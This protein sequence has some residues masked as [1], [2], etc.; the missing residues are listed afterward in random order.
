MFN[1]AIIKNFEIPSKNKLKTKNYLVNFG[2]IVVA[3]LIIL[4]SL[5]YF[6][7]AVFDDKISYPENLTDET[8]LHKY[9]IELDEEPLIALYHNKSQIPQRAKEFHLK[10]FDP[11]SHAVTF[12]LIQDKA[13]KIKQKQDEILS[14]ILS[15]REK[16][17]KNLKVSLLN[18]K[19][20][21]KRFSKV[22]SGLALELTPE[23]VEEIKSL[24]YVKSVEPDITLKFY[25]PTIPHTNP[26]SFS[27]E[28][29]TSFSNLNLLSETLNYTGKGIKVAII[30]SGVDYTH[31]DLGGCTLEQI[32]A[33]N[34][35]KIIDVYDFGEDDFDPMDDFG[36]GTHCAGII[37]ANGTLKGVAPDAQLMVYKVSYIVSINGGLIRLFFLPVSAIINAL[38][39]SLDPNDDLDFSDRADVISLSLGAAGGEANDYL[40]RIL[41]N[42]VKA[43]IFVSA[44]A[45]NDGNQ[46]YIVSDPSTSREAVSVAAYNS[47][48]GKIASFSSG[49]PALVWQYGS[50]ITPVGS[51]IFKPEIAAPGVDI[52]STAARG[53]C[54]LC[55]PSG[56]T[57]LSGTSMAT[58]Y[59][60]GVAALILERS[61]RENLSLT[62]RDVKS[63]ILSYAKDLG[64]PLWLQ[65]TGLVNISSS[66]N[67]KI[68]FDPPVINFEDL[69]IA[70][71]SKKNLRIRNLDNKTHTLHF[72]LSSLGDYSDYFIISNQTITINPQETVNV[73]LSLNS[74]KTMS[75][76]DLLGLIKVEDSTLD[77]SKTL[78]LPLSAYLFAYYQMNNMLG[79]KIVS[80]NLTCDQ[81]KQN[82]DFKLAILAK[83]QN[84]MPNYQLLN[85]SSS[86]L[87]E[88]CSLNTSFLDS[89]KVDFSAVLF[90]YVKYNN[91]LDYY[92]IPQDLIYPTDKSYV[93]LTFNLSDVKRNKVPMSFDNSSVFLRRALLNLVSK[94]STSPYDMH[95]NYFDVNYEAQYI[96]DYP[97]PI[98]DETVYFNQRDYDIGDHNY[99]LSLE[100]W[101]EWIKPK[102]NL[103]ISEAITQSR[104][105]IN[106]DVYIYKKRFVNTV[107]Q[108]IF[109]I[110]TSNREEYY[111]TQKIPFDLAKDYRAYRNIVYVNEYG[112]LRPEPIKDFL[113][114]GSYRIVEFEPTSKASFA[115]VNEYNVRNGTVL[116]EIYAKEYGTFYKGFSDYSIITSDQR[117]SFKNNV[118]LGSLI[119]SILPMS[120]FLDSLED[121]SGSFLVS[122]DGS[123]L[124]LYDFDIYVKNS[125]YDT[126]FYYGAVNEFLYSNAKYYY[127]ED[128]FLIP[129]SNYK[130]VDNQNL[131]ELTYSLYNLSIFNSVNVSLIFNPSICPEFPDVENLTFSREDDILNISFDYYILNS[132]TVALSQLMNNGTEIIKNPL[133]LTCFA[134]D[135]DLY[136]CYSEINLSEQ[137]LA[138][139]N[140][141]LFIKNN[142]CYNSQE[143]NISPFYIE[144][145][146]RY[147]NLSNK[148]VHT[149]E[150]NNISFNVSTEDG[151]LLKNFPVK[152]F[153]NDSFISEVIASENTTF[154]LNLSEY[155]S[156]PFIDLTF[157]S[158][159]NYPYL[160]LN[161]TVRYYLDFIFFSPN[162]NLIAD[163][164][165]TI[166]LSSKRADVCEYNLTYL[167]NSSLSSSGQLIKNG[168]FFYKTINLDSEGDYYLNVTCR[169]SS[170]ITVGFVERTFTVDYLPPSYQMILHNNLTAGN[171]TPIS[172]F[173]NEPNLKSMLFFIEDPLGNV[174]FSLNGISKVC[175]FS[176]IPWEIGNYSFT[177]NI[178]DIANHVTYA[179]EVYSSKEPENVS[180]IL[181]V[182]T[183]NLTI[184][185][186]E[187]NESINTSLNSSFNTTVP[188][189]ENVTLIIKENDTPHAKLIIENVSLAN[190][191]LSLDFVKNASENSVI[192]KIVGVKTIIPKLKSK[193][194]FNLS[195]INAN[196]DKIVPFK[197]Y[198][199]DMINHSCQGAWEEYNNYTKDLTKKII[200][201]NVSSFSAYSV[202]EEYY[203]GDSTCDPDETCDSCPQDCGSC[204]VVQPPSV[205]GGGGG[206]SIPSKQEVSF[207]CDYQQ[208]LRYTDLLYHSLDE[209]FTNLSNLSSFYINSHN[210]QE[211]FNRL[212]LCFNEIAE[213]GALN[214]EMLNLINLTNLSSQENATFLMY[215]LSAYL[216]DSRGNY[217]QTD[218]LNLTLNFRFNCPSNYC[219]FEFD[220]FEQDNV[221]K[222]IIRNCSQEHCTINI[223]SPLGLVLI[224]SIVKEQQIIDNS[225]TSYNASTNV[226]KTNLTQEANINDNTNQQ[227]SSLMFIESPKAN[228]KF[229]ISKFF[230]K[231]FDSIRCGIYLLS[232]NLAHPIII[233]ILSLLIVALFL[234][235]TLGPILIK[236][237][238]A[239]LY[240]KLNEE[241]TKFEQDL[242]L[243]NFVPSE[244]VLLRMSYLED[245]IKKKNF[246]DLERRLDFLLKK[247][248]LIQEK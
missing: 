228:Q 22:F 164:S 78:S 206:S 110:D 161:E 39:E 100:L 209:R 134:R 179:K 1:R 102:T 51:F 25:V 52:N 122:P 195:D 246:K 248:K 8:S 84:Y 104:Q 13:S 217:E 4:S 159:E 145:I 207:T 156:L 50:D 210:V 23:E 30:D 231:V 190:L 79:I 108:D 191:N 6:S 125:N 181:N 119:F 176:F 142:A 146:P 233:T 163:N 193:L 21:V 117:I 98:N 235:L 107:N 214:E 180:I 82:S 223:T 114:A 169:N 162:K 71:Y 200:L 47:S 118:T 28:N 131:F 216:K 54:D 24:P 19:N 232:Q 94:N 103:T 58:P 218:E 124:L 37:A 48:S 72:N 188:K 141:S 32:L 93:L 224:K 133:N 201:I 57:V 177:I 111:I 63:L 152:I 238:N 208:E 61:N 226:S 87:D 123:H 31:P 34:C 186:E 15:I 26:V 99:N 76:L 56:Y 121:T 182:S 86:D 225:L 192:K 127:P 173:I 166:N 242:K 132:H 203:C 202:G 40:S 2:L 45:G 75:N 151:V 154:V 66:L 227:K 60:S 148:A 128:F 5:I 198:D 196:L 158:P 240:L 129:L 74:S 137:N 44:A 171:R 65:G 204:P 247:A 10:N 144:E 184:V 92:L 20:K 3:F 77:D 239:K 120:R 167:D 245:V 112:I 165:F 115:V 215:N 12:Q 187:L 81:I 194:I 88:N 178:S 219:M 41:D 189:P 109:P 55:D 139:V 38:E 211:L 222:T 205:G 174:V 97:I 9:I 149:D 101:F 221:S 14:Q 230:V 95:Y 106:Y 73:T 130:D 70:Y 185:I 168:T 62:P 105:N 53:I 42:L 150:L 46:Q 27:L 96:Y 17:Q 147:V 35:S 138:S 237:N 90:G 170:N 11:N 140:I 29:Q 18:S 67:G 143:I 183:E 160:E 212:V 136:T 126:L 43:G 68:V 69:S 116:K 89:L 236:K 220:I 85:I 80:D 59:I 199:W 36:H 16:N 83:N 234:L 49:G 241:I 155:S 157:Y 172:I 7:Y 243:N 33:K 135:T 229:F 64:E 91:T 113:T 175:N 153:I 197:C 244:D 213:L